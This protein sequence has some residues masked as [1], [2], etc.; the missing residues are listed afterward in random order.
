[1]GKIRAWKAAQPNHRRASATTDVP[2]LRDSWAKR[3]QQRAER[4]V[5]QAAQAAIDEQIR[6]EKREARERRE[7]KA[8]KEEEDKTRGLQYQ[9]ISNPAKLKKMS[10]KQLRNVRKMDTSGVAPK[11]MP[12]AK[13]GAGAGGARGGAIQKRGR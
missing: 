3:Q 13:A 12:K 2:Q 7:A 6:S 5:M 10:K 8:A 4:A 9:V 11:P 1:M